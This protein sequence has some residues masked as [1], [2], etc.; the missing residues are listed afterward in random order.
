MRATTLFSFLSSQFEVHNEFG[1]VVPGL[2][3]RAH[4][5]A[6]PV[7]FADLQDRA[8]DVLRSVDAVGVTAGPGLSLCLNVGYRF[9]SNLAVSLGVP[10]V[11]VNHIEAH[12][13]SPRL[14]VRRGMLSAARNA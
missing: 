2:A 10:L 13:L 1:G 14:H 12:A 4:E 8:S 3:A 11:H 7:G 9:A 6:L 5:A